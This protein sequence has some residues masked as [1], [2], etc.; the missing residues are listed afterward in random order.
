MSN[1]ATEAPLAGAPQMVQRAALWNASL[2]ARIGQFFS[3]AHRAITV[4]GIAALFVLGLMFFNPDLADKLISMSPFSDSADDVQTADAV[5]VPPLAELM[6]PAA[7]VP[8]IPVIAGAAAT[9]SAT[10][11]AMS[12]EDRQLLGTPR[13]Q[14]LVTSWLA[15]RYRVANDAADMLVS[16]TYLTA[17]DIKLD[18]LLILSV[19]A[20]ESRFNPFAESPMG[21]QGLMQV[22]SKVHHDK[23]QDL[24]GIKAALN[25]VANIRVGSQILKEYVTRGGSIEAGLKSYVGAA[26]MAND[27]GYGVKVLSEYQNLKQVAMGK[28]VSIYTTATVKLPPAAPAVSASAEPKPAAANNVASASAAKPRTEEQ[29]AAL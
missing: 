22:M 28:N 8:T 27:G 11:P 14:K 7:P 10:G 18:P 3:V 25:P 24:G 17:R 26:D 6:S 9:A 15:K 29:L 5:A 13:Q 2:N 20:I 12:A 4:L 21:A 19:I 1:Q 23:F 16:A